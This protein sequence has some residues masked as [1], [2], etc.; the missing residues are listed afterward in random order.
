M[1][2]ANVNCIKCDKDFQVDTRYFQIF[3][4]DP[5]CRDCAIHTECQSCNR[6][7]RLAPSRYQEL[8]GGPVICTDCDQ[9][10]SASPAAQGQQNRS[11]SAR[12]SSG[13]SFWTGLSIGEKIVFPLLLAALLG[14]GWLALSAEL[15]G[16]EFSGP[17]A[18]VTV[19][20]VWLHRRGKKNS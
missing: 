3:G 11:S 16:G 6:G 4:E 5:I 13:G 18:G 12:S 20:L 15:N 10:P 2:Q 1:G 19:L 17:I 14:M 9:Q 7:L 8:G